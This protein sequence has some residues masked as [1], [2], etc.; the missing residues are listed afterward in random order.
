[1][2]MKLNKAMEVDQKWEAVLEFEK[3]G[4]VTVKM[5]VIDPAELKADKKM[6]HSG[7]SN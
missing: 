7:H 5:S 1:M 6:D 3:A 4:K 2:F